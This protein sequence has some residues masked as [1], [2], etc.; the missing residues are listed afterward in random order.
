MDVA[1]AQAAVEVAQAGVA[2]AEA[3]LASAQAGYQDLLIGPN[4][5]QQHD[6]R[7]AAAPGRNRARN[8]RSRPTTRSRTSPMPACFPRPPSWNRPLLTMRWP[9]PRSPRPKNR[10]PRHSSPRAEP[11]RPGAVWPAPGPGPGGQRPEQP[12]QPA[13]RPQTGRHRHCARPGQAG[14]VEPVAGRKYADQCAPG[15]ALRRRR[16]PGQCQ[17]GR[18]VD[19]CGC[20]PSCSPT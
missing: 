2:G 14:A 18:A 19:E 9:R 15:G 10:P 12:G 17:A 5:T 8:R 16:Q 1:A 20:R 4:T 11:D 13:G 6:Q 7:L 3:A